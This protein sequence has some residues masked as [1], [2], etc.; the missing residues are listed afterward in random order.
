MVVDNCSK[1]NSVKNIKK[2]KNHKIDIIVSDKNGGYGYGNNL[3]INYLVEHYSSKYI[4]LSNP[5]IIVDEETINKMENFLQ[6]NTD[7]VIVAPFMLDS[8]GKKQFNTAFRIPGKME[9]ILSLDMLISKLKKSFYYKNIEQEKGEYKQVGS[10]SGSMFLMNAE[11]MTKYGMY[12]ENI[13]LYCEEIVLG[14]KMKKNNQKIALLL[15]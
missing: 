7:F 10:V 14:L 5:D 15:K 3:G 2:Y 4:L 13:F 8:N 9:Y 6:K 12:D 1:D 11:K